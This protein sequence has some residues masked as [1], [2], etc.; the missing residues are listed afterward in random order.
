[1]QRFRRRA[2]C[3]PARSQSSRVLRDLRLGSRPL[4][5]SRKPGATGIERTITAPE[6]M[7]STTVIITT[8]RVIEGREL[9]QRGACVGLLLPSVDVHAR[10]GTVQPGD[11]DLLRQVMQ[12][13]AR[14]ALCTGTAKPEATQRAFK[15]MAE[16]IIEMSAPCVV[17]KVRFILT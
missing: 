9:V 14:L 1:M 17:V 10:H 13:F 16:V 11:V 12:K 8:D 4:D 5:G 3:L 15:V 7:P 6:A 2:H